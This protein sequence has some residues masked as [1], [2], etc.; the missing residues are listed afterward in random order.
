MRKNK[1]NCIKA[2]FIAGALSLIALIGDSYYIVSANDNIEN[3]LFRKIEAAAGIN[4][5]AEAKEDIKRVLRLNPRHSGAIFYAGQYCFQTGD[6]ENAQKFL[7]RII[8][9][10]KY[11]SK[12]NSV[13]ADIRLK[14]YNKHFMETLRVYLTGESFSQALKLCEDALLDMPNNQDL[15]FGASYA[16]CMLGKKDKAESY[17]E[18]YAASTGNSPLAAELKTLV[19]AWFADSFDS[20]IAIEKFLSI[21][22]KRLLSPAVKNKIKNLLI[23]SKSI[24]RYEDFIRNEAQQPGADKDNLE[25]ELITFLLEQ[26]HFEK[27]LELINNRPVESLEDNLLYVWGLCATNQHIKALNT[28]RNLISVAPRDLRVYRAWTEAWVSYVEKNKVMPEGKDSS[29]RFYS[30]TVNE[31]FELLRPNR[32]I[33]QEPILLINLLRMASFCGNDTQAQKLQ[34]EVAKIPF[35]NEH[36]KILLKTA[37][38]LVSFERIRMAANILESAVN[39]LPNNY[40][41]ALKLA[42]IY[43]ERNPAT[44]IRICEEI[45]EQHPELLRAF[46][47]W[48]DAMHLAKRG[49]E[50]VSKILKRLEDDSINDLVKRQLNSKLEQLR[51]FGN[52]STPYVANNGMEK[53]GNY[54]NNTDGNNLGDELLDQITGSDINSY[55]P[56][57]EEED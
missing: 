20:A 49:D 1:Q 43:Q 45:M 55:S 14:K 46:M 11:G 10:P 40:N 18:L 28:A 16:S 44:S 54:E 4:N 47:Q 27:A 39:Q 48:C 31:L 52:S 33:T 5:L 42:Q 29:G 3:K 36:E 6:F 26:N 50:A 25:R 41:I 7:K 23:S 8:N 19:D 24:N 51:M 9:D 2:V 32:L 13:L 21:K 53:E 30:E 35:N 34:A 12:A 57:D 37:D 17:S 15:L 38:E 22:D 56:P